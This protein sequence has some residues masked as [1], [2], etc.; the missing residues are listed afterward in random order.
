VAEDLAAGDVFG[1]FSVEE[2]IGRGGMGLVYRAVQVGLHRKIALKIIAPHLAEDPVFQDRFRREARQAAAIDHPAIIPIYAAGEI[3][4]RLYLAM[5]YVPG[6]DLSSLLLAEGHLSPART[7]AILAQIAGA[8]DAA[9]AGG[10][11]HRDVKPANILI[12]RAAAGRERAYLTDFGLVRHTGDTHLT[13][14]GSW[15]GTVNYMPPEQFQAA[16]KVDGRA[17][18]YSLACVAYEMLTGAPPF[19][20][21]SD[22]Q[23]MFAHLNDPPPQVSQARPE[24]PAEMDAVLARAMAKRPG[25]R[26]GSC[27]AFVSAFALAA[28]DLRRS[29]TLFDDPVSLP[30][31]APTVIEGPAAKVTG[32][33][34]PPAAARTDATGSGG[35]RSG[36]RRDRAALLG[37]AAVIAIA[38][39]LAVVL[40]TRG[41]SHN[42]AEQA[43]GGQRSAGRGG[44]GTTTSQTAALLD[45]GLPATGSGILSLLDSTPSDGSVTLSVNGPRAGQG[46]LRLTYDAKL[47]RIRYYG[48]KLA[49]EYV[50]DQPS[51]RLRWACVEMKGKPT[52]CYPH[53][54]YP[55]R[56]GEVP[57]QLQEVTVV[58]DGSI[59]SRIA[60]AELTDTFKLLIHGAHPPPV[61]LS[62]QVG[63]PVA[64]ISGTDAEGVRTLCVNR[65]GVPTYVHISNHGKDWIYFRA[66]KIAYAL[67]PGAFDPP[68]K[69]K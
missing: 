28:G 62:H 2:L 55:L 51:S 27:S 40:I 32:G 65:N 60:N 11:V 34:G 33:S 39:A 68:A 61:T 52:H 54:T 38:I 53:Q 42:H 31:I 17:D 48:P 45:A 3:E 44:T 18:Q 46:T 15:L 1:D 9:H 50:L 22:P 5:R 66:I 58:I 30:V 36:V 24:L 37:G 20:R 64:C 7:F 41:S 4:G 26:F 14:T 56:H 19:P 23:A 67:G 29:E 35:R 16:G 47:L 25:D 69:L 57:N 6:T 12:E 59:V 21:D 10:L 43:S 63:V 13:Q 49:Y 8:L